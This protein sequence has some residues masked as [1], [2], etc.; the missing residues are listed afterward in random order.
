MVMDSLRYWVEEMHVD[1]FRFD[2]A[3]TLGR[4][5]DL[6]FDPGSSFFDAIRQDPVLARIKLIAEPW[7]IG[8]GGYRLG[9]HGPGWAEWND[10]FRDTL[11]SFWK[12]DEGQLPEL[13]TRLVG[14]ADLFAHQGRRA[15]ASVNFAA[16]HDGFTLHDTVSYNEKHNEANGE[17]NRDGHS[18]NLSWNCGVEGPA[19]DPLIRALRQRQKRNMLATVLLAHGTPMILMGDE[20]GRTQSGNNNAYCQ[21]NAIS[22]LDWGRIDADGRNL[23]AFV[24]RLVHLRRTHPL[25]A[26]SRFFRG[27]DVGGGLKDRGLAGAGRERDGRGGLAEPPGQ[28]P[29][30]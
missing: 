20:L 27:A 15:W 3:T 25:L 9:G 10:R 22:W 7:D 28:S 6:R 14:S 23:I 17:G 29:S 2:L 4:E 12:G 19:D 21:D 26:S 11:R 5:R 16:A 1:G 8:P 18:H 30:P 13:T 24:A